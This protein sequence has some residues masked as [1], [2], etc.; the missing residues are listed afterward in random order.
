MART[1]ARWNVM[2]HGNSNRMPMWYL[3]D[4]TSQNYS[5]QNPM[6]LLSPLKLWPYLHD[7]QFAQTIIGPLKLTISFRT[8]S[9]CN[10]YITCHLHVFWI[11]L[12]KLHLWFIRHMLWTCV[13]NHFT[14]ITHIF[15]VPAKLCRRLTWFTDSLNQHAQDNPRLGYLETWTRFMLPGGSLMI[16]HGSA[17]RQ[18][19]T[20]N[21]RHMKTAV[22]S[23]TSNCLVYTQ[24]S[25][26]SLYGL[27]CI[28]MCPKLLDHVW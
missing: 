26:P 20:S 8:Y 15:K 6:I 21:G 24:S 7:P 16:N 13:L 17:R 25:L 12:T 27:H 18:S 11:I 14:I 2:T 22:I 4:V 5:P 1:T 10:P 28:A 9:F 19:N 23:S 3:R